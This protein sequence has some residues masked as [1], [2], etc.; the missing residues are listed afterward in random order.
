MFRSIVYFLSFVSFVS[1]GQ[2]ELVRN[3][4]KELC[5]PQMHGRGYVNNG[6]SLAAFYLLTEYQKMGL[7]AAPGYST[8]IQPFQFPVNTFPGKME[9]NLNEEHLVPGQDFIVSPASGSYH[10]KLTPY[11]VTKDNFYLVESAINLSAFLDRS[12]Y[13]SI[14]LD[15]KG[16]T[17]DSLKLLT[18]KIKEWN[19]KLPIVELFS[20]K[21]TW[22]V[23]TTTI[24]FPYV[25]LR[26]SVYQNQ[27]I[28][29]DIENKFISNHT[30][31]NIV[32]YIPAKKKT[33]KTIYFTAHYDHLGRMGAQTYFPG[34]NDNASGTAMLLALAQNFKAHPSKYNIVFVSFAGEEAGLLG[35]HYY[36]ENPMTPLKDIRFLINLDIMGSGEDGITIV[37]ASIF[38]KA[39]KKFSKI[40]KKRKLLKSVNS[41]GPAANS[42]HYFFTEKGVPAVFIYTQ[43]PNK[44]Y[45]DIYDTYAE[46]T[47]AETI[48]LLE[49]L[50]VFVKKI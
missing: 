49:L 13:N 37:N 38:P 36:V 3:W 24:A 41:R 4:T 31:Y 25:Y 20:S 21:F 27:S 40:N 18:S 19:E 5:S 8:M 42:D 17:G 32:T 9:V 50:K 47:F 29:L 28:S 1:F 46:L 39:F 44:H 22:S 16:I 15:K 11:P 45:H 6:D 26:D 10:G 33:D 2:E 12:K 43:G 14:L 23:S 35:S 34:G 48:D 7:Q 30:A